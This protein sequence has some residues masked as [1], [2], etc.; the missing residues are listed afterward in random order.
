MAKNLRKFAP[1]LSDQLP[2]NHDYCE[3]IVLDARVN[4]AS[5]SRSVI[6]G[7]SCGRWC[8]PAGQGMVPRNDSDW[9]RATNLKLHAWSAGGGG[10]G[11]CCCMYGHPG[12]G[13]Y[14]MQSCRKIKE[15]E[16]YCYVMGHGGCCFPA[17]GVSGCFTLIREAS[18]CISNCN[19]GGWCGY[20]SCYYDYCCWDRTGQAS[21][22][23]AASNAAMPRACYDPIGATLPYRSHWMVKSSC[24]SGWLNY[25][26]PTSLHEKQSTMLGGHGRRPWDAGTNVTNK[27][28]IPGGNDKANAYERH[29]PTVG[30]RYCLADNC[31]HS[32]EC[33][34][35]PYT[36]AVRGH[37]YG[38]HGY[39]S[40]NCF[41]GCAAWVCGNHDWTWG[42]MDYDRTSGPSWL[43]TPQ[44]NAN[45]T[46]GGWNSS[47]WL[48][49]MLGGNNNLCW[50]NIRT[51]GYGGQAARVCAGP[52]CCGGWGMHGYIN[53]QY[54]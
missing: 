25:I 14:Y 41:T 21:G 53:F 32:A 22:C 24:A 42:N 46:C 6:Y 33:S 9:G 36:P 26:Q 3:F 23:Q 1:G 18:N 43:N 5:N 10:A 4:D 38:G 35:K 49:C 11:S 15:G 50:T 45:M 17:L 31:M 7:N 29:L 13:G 44:Q 54:R 37:G 30:Q 47:R 52:C 12:G 39:T 34:N 48:L 16:T 20:S 2:K 27:N 8:A 51:V 28:S 40:M 19:Q